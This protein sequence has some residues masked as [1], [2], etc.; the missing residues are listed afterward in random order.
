[1]LAAFAS[2]FL[3]LKE[4]YVHDRF[5]NFFLFIAIFAFVVV[6]HSFTKNNTVNNFRALAERLKIDFHYEKPDIISELFRE[7]HPELSGLYMERY[8]LRVY[9]IVEG[10][11]NSAKRYVAFEF[12]ALSN[13]P[14]NLTLMQE[15]VF[16]KMG[17]ALGMQADVEVRDEEFDQKF[18]VKTDDA[19]F[20][21]QVLGD[22]DLRELFLK[23]YHLFTNG[24]LSFSGGTIRYKGAGF[25]SSTSSINETA[26]MVNL[27]VVLAKIL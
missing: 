24:Q 18:I 9:V 11:G 23:D 7:V 5:S 4:N 10:G 19:S 1:M 25:F 21:K 20:A 3:N 2:F 16:R 17:K 26:G 22:P 13:K 15:G 27:G 6:I 8:Q 14:H 12:D